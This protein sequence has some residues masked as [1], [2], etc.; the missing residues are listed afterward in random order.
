MSGELTAWELQRHALGGLRRLPAVED[1]MG[2]AHSVALTE[3][4]QTACVQCLLDLGPEHARPTV[5]RSH[6]LSK[7]IAVLVFWSRLL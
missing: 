5:L 4:R 2:I 7:S 1:T 3:P 6:S